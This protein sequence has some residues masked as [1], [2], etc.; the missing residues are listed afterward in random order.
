MRIFHQILI[1]CQVLFVV[2]V[3]GQD[4]LGDIH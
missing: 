4:G 3:L 1:V 2:I